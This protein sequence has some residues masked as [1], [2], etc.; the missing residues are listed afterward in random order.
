MNFIKIFIITKLESSI[1]PKQF[2]L[3]PLIFVILAFS[4]V[5]TFAAVEDS[6][7]PAGFKCEK[8]LNI[9]DFLSLARARLRK[10]DNKK[11]ASLMKKNRQFL[12]VHSTVYGWLYG[13]KKLIEFLKEMSISN[14]DIKLVS[15]FQS[16]VEQ[17]RITTKNLLKEF[18]SKDPALA[19]VLLWLK[20]WTANGKDLEKFP[21][22]A[23]IWNLVFANWA[24]SNDSYRD[25]SRALLRLL[26]FLSEDREF[27]KFKKKNSTLVKNSLYPYFMAHLSIFGELAP[28]FA[29][30]KKEEPGYKRISKI[31]G[32]VIK[33]MKKYP[34]EL[35]DYFGFIGYCPLRENHESI[36]R[37]QFRKQKGLIS[38]Q[39]F[40]RGRITVKGKTNLDLRYNASKTRQESVLRMDGRTIVAGKN[41]TLYWPQVNGNNI[42]TTSNSLEVGPLK[43]NLYLNIVF[44]FLKKKKK[45]AIDFNFAIHNASGIFLDWQELWTLLADTPILVYESKNKRFTVIRYRPAN[46][47]QTVRLIFGYSQGHLE[48]LKITALKSGSSFLFHEFV[49]GKNQGTIFPLR[50]LPDGKIM[51]V[52]LPMDK[53]FLNRVLFNRVML[54]E[55]GNEEGTGGNSGE[56]EVFNIIKNDFLRKARHKTGESIILAQKYHELAIKYPGIPSLWAISGKFHIDAYQFEKAA[57]ALRKYFDIDEEIDDEERNIQFQVPA[58]TNAF[59]YLINALIHIGDYRGARKNILSEIRENKLNGEKALY[60]EMEHYM[61]LADVNARRGAWQ[62]SIAAF[63]KMEKT[64]SSFLKGNVLSLKSLLFSLRM[65]L[66]KIQILGYLKKFEKGGKALAQYD[67]YLAENSSKL[68]SNLK[69]LFQERNFLLPKAWPGANEDGVRLPFLPNLMGQGENYCVPIAVQFIL[70]FYG[71]KS[72]SQKEI[73]LRM[74]TTDKGTN[75]MNMIRYLK[76]RNFQ[77]RAFIGSREAI[78]NYLKKGLPVITLFFPKNADL[79]HMVAIIGIDR[80]SGLLYLY[81][82]GE[83]FAIDTIKARDLSG[84]QTTTGNIFLAFVRSDAKG[85]YSGLN[86]VDNALAMQVLNYL[87]LDSG[88]SWQQNPEKLL[89][90]IETMDENGKLKNF[91]LYQRAKIMLQKFYQKS[92]TAEDKKVVSE[93]IRKNSEKIRKNGKIKDLY[94]RL[95]GIFGQLAYFLNDASS[96]RDAFMTATMDNSL[97]IRSFFSLGG[98]MARDRQYKAALAYFRKA[99]FLSF[100]YQ[101]VIPNFQRRILVSMAKVAQLEKDYK[102]SASFLMLAANIFNDRSS[103]TGYA[104]NMIKMSAS[105]NTLRFIKANQPR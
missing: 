24:F 70:R 99:Y 35:D 77:T 97:D 7:V 60:R 25:A 33:I 31:R 59:S 89:K 85:S 36:L 20:N 30:L 105:P 68:P 54:R 64:T 83:T 10:I 14:D 6:G 1:F 72:T 46:P 57:D 39:T 103:L 66:A 69:K 16:S 94:Y 88:G 13:N 43:R 15:L 95:Q 86:D 48:E 101:S 49:Y 65:H 56:K 19:Q 104:L 44:Q 78:S 51:A 81:E 55:G 4:T 100:Q 93:M 92:I 52:E 90:K 74:G 75:F 80:Q 5:R 71:D 27:R 79:G 87:D 84:L 102:K 8:Q 45:Y 23:G 61:M 32:H 53:I 50:Y 38:N 42:F 28:H 41:G 12:L 40:Q 73:A 47:F 62:E 17:K 26:S 9:K 29:A 91:I 37:R 2:F 67:K 11:L 58:I 82:P 22:N 63:E 3:F 76:K 21:E 96:A 18:K 34:V 98:L